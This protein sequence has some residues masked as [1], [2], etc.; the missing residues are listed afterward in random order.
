MSICPRAVRKIGEKAFLLRE[1]T[2]G[3]GTVTH[4]DERCEQTR[5]DHPKVD[6]AG[7]GGR[8][9]RHVPLPYHTGGREQAGGHASRCAVCGKGEH[10]CACAH[11][12]RVCT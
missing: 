9:L 7:S 8:A 10:A 12:Q 11:L 4:N 5:E 6:P 3:H 1:L 2:S